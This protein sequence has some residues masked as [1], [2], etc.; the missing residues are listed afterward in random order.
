MKKLIAAVSLFALPMLT[1]AQNVVDA[2]TLIQKFNRILNAAIP[3]IVTLA[4]IWIVWY[5]FK[6]MIA[7]GDEDKQKSKTGIAYG[8]V[9]LFIILSIWGL[10]NILVRTFGLD[11]RVPVE[12]LPKVIQT[13]TTI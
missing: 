12:Q 6:F 1:F 5:I 4:V 8:V 2:N 9:G 7:G 10:V 11:N 3:I 13:T